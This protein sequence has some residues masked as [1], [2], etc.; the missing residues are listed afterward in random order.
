M[1]I[2]S[3]GVAL[4]PEAA[5]HLERVGEASRLFF[6]AEADALAR[7]CWDMARRFHRGGRLLVVGSETS[8]S[9][10]YHV[11]VEFLHPVL[12]GKCALPALV[13]EGDAAAWTQRFGRPDDIAMGL[14]DGADERVH[15]MLKA[16]QSS[17]MLTVALIGAAGGAMAD[18]VFALPES[19][20]LVMQEV[21]E[22][23][24]HMLYELVHVFLEQEGLL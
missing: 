23:C 14:I 24:Y 4:T 10:A 8:E 9:D 21:R 1:T 16:A 5:G 13:L 3:P 17:G 7:A 15:A 11:S 20:P 18:H 19:D 2:V 12:V 6:A 22:T